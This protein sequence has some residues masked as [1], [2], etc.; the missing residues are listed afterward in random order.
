MKKLLILLAVLAAA[1][2]MV[3]QTMTAPKYLELTEDEIEKR[4][5]VGLTPQQVA[6]ALGEPAEVTDVGGQDMMTWNYANSSATQADKSR[7]HSFSVSF[8]NG[9]VA[10]YLLEEK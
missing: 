10:R 4:V 3:F 9:V 5:Q 1:G 8:E 6:A 2:L 7:P